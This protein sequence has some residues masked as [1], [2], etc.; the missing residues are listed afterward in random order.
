MAKLYNL[1]RM[2]TATTGTGTITLGSAVAG[3]LSFVS[4]GIADGDVITYAIQDGS[5]S[6]IGRGTYTASGATLTR[7]VLKS[8]NSNALIS[9]SGSAQVFITPAAEDFLSPGLATYDGAARGASNLYARY[10]TAAQILVSCDVVTLYT[11]A[12]EPKSFST[13]SETASL[14]SSGAGGLDTGAE[15][16]STWYYGWLIGKPDG[17]I[18]LLLSTSATS[19]T[20]PTG[21]TFRGRVTAFYNNASS[22][23]DP[24]AQRAGLIQR[25]AQAA[26]LTNGT[27][28]ATTPYASISLTA[29]IPPVAKTVLLR[30]VLSTS[31][32]TSFVT[33]SITG[34]SAGTYYIMQEQIPSVTTTGSISLLPEAIIQTASTIYYR[35]QGTNAQTTI[36]VIGWRLF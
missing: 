2:T 32:G 28:T 1:A 11:S 36:T 20:M 26:V 9:L 33:L 21:Y 22:N 10:D 13:V 17:T 24:Y 18:D 12:G 19:P 6:E 23:I 34:D 16:S 30:G 25:I 7:S 31:S 35:V 14:A 8:T 27:S 5:N 3:F 29:D 4:A 15:A